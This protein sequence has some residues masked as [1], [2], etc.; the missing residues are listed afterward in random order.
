MRRLLATFAVLAWATPAAAQNCVTLNGVSQCQAP[1][2]IYDATVRVL[3]LPVIDLSQT[4]NSSSTTFTGLKLNITDTNSATASK[5]IDLQVNGTSKFSVTKAGVLSIGGSDVPLTRVSAYNLALIAPLASATTPQFTVQGDYGSAYLNIDK[6]SAGD[7]SRLQY[8]TNGS[9]SYVTGLLGDASYKIQS[10]G[11]TN[12][13]IANSTGQII[14]LS[15]LTAVARGAPVEVGY[16]RA[17]AQS[18]AVASVATFTVGAADGSFEVSANVLVTT[19]TTHTFTVQCTYTDEGN[20]ARTVTLPFR[21]VGDTTALTSSITNTNGTVP[22]LGVPVYLRAKSGTVITVL[23]QA[24]G[25][26]TTVTF[27]VEG[28][29]KQTS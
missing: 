29:I 22:Y 21:L 1:W 14:G 27:N 13:F 18:A 3:S 15:G 26:Y 6:Q 16:G 8:M 2:Q 20:T 7:D 4:W 23:T 25:T 11:G 19:A 24:A 28:L 5:L 17:A 9:A 10:G 12:A